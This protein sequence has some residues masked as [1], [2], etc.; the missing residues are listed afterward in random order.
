[1]VFELKHAVSE[2]A[3]WVNDLPD[4]R[5]QKL[6]DLGRE[7]LRRRYKLRPDLQQAALQWSNVDVVMSLINHVSDP[8]TLDL[9]LD[10]YEAFCKLEEKI[11]NELIP[12]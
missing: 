1:M 7:R 3:R 2:M 5:K 4:A 10:L 6:V 9:M 11:F 8:C 12:K